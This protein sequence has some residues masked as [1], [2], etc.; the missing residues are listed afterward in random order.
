LA[1]TLTACDDEKAQ[2]DL[3]ARVVDSGGA[4]PAPSATV[5]AAPAY[6]AAPSPKPKLTCRPGPEV[7]FHGNTAL[8]TEVRRKIGKDA[9]AVTIGD[10][11]TIKSLNL[12]QATVN[13]LDP[14]IFPLF[15]SVKDLFLGAGDLDDLTPI[16]GLTQLI[17]LRASINKLS[18]L[19]P[20]TKMTQMDRLDL[21]R[22]A[23]HDIS[24]LANMVALTEL[25]LDDTQV[26][27]LTPLASCTK[28]ERLS[29]RNTPVVDVSPL[30]GAKKMRYLY[31]EGAPVADTNVLSSLQ[32]GGLK[33][34]RKG[35]M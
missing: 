2:S 35:R 19:R 9:G 17:T 27:D 18:D 12:S 13:D 28:L 10:L 16:A 29:I 31:I 11:K 21:G 30:R 8:E 7:D 34:V 14:C 1:L 23:V 3:V 22:T 20:L 33:I 4:K 6:D 24:P 5:A 26:V 25:Q 32:G 15:T